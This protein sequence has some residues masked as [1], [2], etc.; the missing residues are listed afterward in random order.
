MLKNGFFI[1]NN[2][3]RKKPER[4]ISL[5]PS[6]TELLYDLGLG[7][8]VVG[9]TKFC[10]HPKDWHKTKEKIGGTKKVNIKKVKKLQPDFI[11][12]N[13][14]ENTQEDVELL[15]QIA[16]VW[17]SDIDTLEEAY[18]MILQ[19]GD[20]TGTE[21]AARKIVLFT[22]ERF[23]ELRKVVNLEKTAAYL[24]WRDPWM[25]VGADTFID[26]L[27]NEIGIKNVFRQK[28]RYPEF[29]L[30]ELKDLQPDY[31]FLSSEPYPFKEKHIKELQQQSI[32][33][34]FKLVDGEMFSWY[35]SRLMKTPQ[36]LM[37]IFGKSNQ[38][39]QS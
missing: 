10:I 3:L 37:E 14:E 34:E 15:N 21:K 18:N 4:I 6:Q 35:G 27:L 11:I 28:N 9:I 31:I 16:P 25:A 8:K 39:S 26:S 30:E 12:A 23:N 5:V 22:Q 33:G 36:Y 17:V 19:I 1:E 29:N 38:S 24:I 20:F 32:E 2:I 7:D 13:K